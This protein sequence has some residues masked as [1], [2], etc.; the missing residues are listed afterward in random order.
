[1]ARLWSSGCAAIRLPPQ[2]GQEPCSAR[3]ERQSRQKAGQ[4]STVICLF[5][6]A[7]GDY[8]SLPQPGGAANAA[9]ITM[10]IFHDAGWRFG[11]E[12]VPLHKL[13]QIGIDAADI[14]K[15]A[16]QHDCVGI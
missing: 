6:A 4:S 11:R 1:M 10:H 13:G 16:T 8:S 9:G 12:S 15:T 14:G 2:K 7:F 5:Q 3:S